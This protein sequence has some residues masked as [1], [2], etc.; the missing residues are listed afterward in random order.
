VRKSFVLLNYEQC[1]KKLV[2]K[3]NGEGS[4]DVIQKTTYKLF[5]E[6]KMTTQEHEVLERQW[7]TADQKRIQMIQNIVSDE[8]GQEQFVLARW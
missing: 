6:V 3:Q 7:Q 4:M 1:E 2:L 8:Q 5:E